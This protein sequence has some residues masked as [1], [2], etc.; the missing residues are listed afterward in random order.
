V[1]RGTR[2]FKDNQVCNIN[3][4]ANKYFNVGETIGYFIVEKTLKYKT[5]LLTNN[6][7]NTN[8]DYK[9]EPLVI[10]P[11]DNIKYSIFKKLESAP[12]IKL[13]RC[14]DKEDINHNIAYQERIDSGLFS[15]TKTNTHTKQLYRSSYNRYNECTIYWVEPNTINP[16]YKVFLNLNKKYFDINQPNKYMPIMYDVGN[17]QNIWAVVCDTKQEAVNTKTYLSSKL[18]RFYIENNKSG[19]FNRIHKLPILNKSHPWS[20]QDIY[21]HFKLTNEEIKLI[22]YATNK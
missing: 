16:K 15:L 20:D 17:Y 8:I 22:E 6:G 3:L 11:E 7:I 12:D 10:E 9:W 2:V 5:T 19:S 18:Y 21:K 14:K 1:R 13:G 4:D